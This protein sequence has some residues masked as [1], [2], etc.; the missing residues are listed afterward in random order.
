MV[1]NAQTLRF[2][3]RLKLYLDERFP[4]VTHGVV[5]STFVLANYFLA[6]RLLHQGP[7]QFG[8]SAVASLF[9]VLLTFFLLRIFDEFK[10]YHKD[11]VAHPDRLVS[12]GV[13]PLDELKTMGWTVTLV[14]ASL[15]LLQGPRVFATYLFVITFAFLMFKEFF[16]GEWLGKH[17]FVYAVSHQVITPLLCLYVYSIAAFQSTGAWHETF[18]LQ[19]LMGAGTG[20]GWELARKIRMPE[21]EQP[22][23]DTYSRDLGPFRSSALAFLILQ[24]GALSAAAIGLQL[25]FPAYALALLGL[26]M[27]VATVGFVRFWLKPTAKGAKGLD[28]WAAVLMLLSYIAIAC[29]AIAPRG[30]HFTF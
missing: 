20:L 6:E 10:D 27:G 21:D 22:L 16:V 9:V 29:G 11:V 4:L 24:A 12:R 23:V 15:T 14:L 26:G 8:W 13:M 30:I 19:L 1:T 28:D 25:A 5:V 18:A 17:L 3:Q 2:P 7:A